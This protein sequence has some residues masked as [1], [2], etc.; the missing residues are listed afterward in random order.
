[1]L[2]GFRKSHRNNTDFPASMHPAFSPGAEK[3]LASAFFHKP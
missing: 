1:M 2:A 3:T